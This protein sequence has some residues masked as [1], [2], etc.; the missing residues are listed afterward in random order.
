MKRK[1][2]AVAVLLGV[3]CLP[4]AWGQSANAQINTFY[5]HLGAEKLYRQG[6][7]ADSESMCKQGITDI[8]KARGKQSYL[9]AEPLMDLA[10]V[11]MRLARYGDAKQ[12]LERADALLD[13][14]KPEQ[15]LLYGRL[16]INKGWRLYTLGETSAATKVFEEARSILEK[17]Q[18]GDSVDL[19][20]IINNLGLMYEEAGEKDE[21]DALIRKGRICL[22][23]GWESRRTLTGEVSPETGE[24]LNNLGMHLMYHA[25][26]LE[27]LELAISTLKKSMEMAIK[28]YGETH[29]ETAVAHATLALALFHEDELEAAEKEIRI[30]LPMTQRFL[31]DRHPDVAFELS[32]LGHILQERNNYDE[33]E[34]K[35]LE[36]LDVDEGVYG[37]TH[38]RIVPALETLKTLYD[39]K[40]DSARS[41]EMKTRIEKLSGKEM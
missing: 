28:V 6:K 37:K 8:E 29:P 23:R 18:K 39:Q 20:E 27:E 25:Q 15:A 32:I 34:K 14:N 40:G 41:R 9:I 7:Y 4:T 21:D 31:G 3:G 10:T 30:A 11:Y 16:G 1:S 13:K 33:A 24:S 22:L 35:Y 19:A 36:A 12:V 2:L 26:S 5:S 38:P 17:N